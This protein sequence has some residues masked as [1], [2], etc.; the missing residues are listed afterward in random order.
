MRVFWL[1]LADLFFG[2]TALSQFGLLSLGN[3]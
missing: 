1:H 3:K 2:I